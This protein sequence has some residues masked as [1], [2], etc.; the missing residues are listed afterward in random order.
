MSHSIWKI[1]KTAYK[2]ANNS[3][4]HNI[5][6]NWEKWDKVKTKFAKA[7]GAR[8]EVTQYAYLQVLDT[9]WSQA[10]ICPQYWSSQQTQENMIHN[11]VPNMCTQ[12]LAPNTHPGWHKWCRRFLQYLCCSCHVQSIPLP[13]DFVL[14]ISGGAVPTPK[15]SLSHLD[16]CSSPV[17]GLPTHP[18]LPPK[19]NTFSTL[20]PQWF[21]FFKCKLDSIRS[22]RNAF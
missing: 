10:T 19:S 17:T 6:L 12:G 5:H 1:F 16:K 8:N 20:Q 22:L 4:G 3:E 13:D 11:A 18:C 9:C 21:F 7:D 15:T 14:W 2:N